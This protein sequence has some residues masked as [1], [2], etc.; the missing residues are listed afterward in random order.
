MCLNHLLLNFTITRK[1]LSTAGCQSDRLPFPACNYMCG[2]YTAHFKMAFCYTEELMYI[3]MEKKNLNHVNGWHF[4]TLRQNFCK[5][6]CLQFYC[7]KKESIYW[8]WKIHLLDKNVTTVCVYFAIFV[9]SMTLPISLLIS[10]F[11]VMARFMQCCSFSPDNDVPPKTQWSIFLRSAKNIQSNRQTTNIQSAD[12]QGC[13]QITIFG[14][15]T[16]FYDLF[17]SNRFSK[18]E[19]KWIWLLSTKKKL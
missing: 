19:K 1:L 17:R 3:L 5:C 15:I 14:S 10:L 4:W 2:F 9:L 11:L 8:Q 18:C 6:L 13:I 12:A 7:D 16:H